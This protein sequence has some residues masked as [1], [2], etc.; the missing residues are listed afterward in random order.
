MNDIV[1]FHEMGAYTLAA[2]HSLMN[3]PPSVVTRALPVSSKSIG[4]VLKLTALLMVEGQ[5]TSSSSGYFGGVAMILLGGQS[6]IGFEACWN[7]IEHAI[8]IAGLDP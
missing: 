4:L 2:R 1:I 8:D 5:D 3:S 6:R 7:Q